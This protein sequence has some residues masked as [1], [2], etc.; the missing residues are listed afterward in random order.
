M[1]YKHPRVIPSAP[2]GEMRS[3]TRRQSR[4]AERSTASLGLH[5]SIIRSATSKLTAVAAVLG[6]SA[7]IVS[8]S[9]PAAAVYKVPP[10]TSASQDSQTSSQSFRA[11]AAVAISTS[12]PLG[13]DG[14]SVTLPPPTAKPVR[15][16]RSVGAFL[17]TNN[18]AG[19]IQWPF[20]SYV[21]IAS[22]FGPRIAP[23]GA[24]SSFHDGV[25]FLPG[26]GAAIGAIAPGIVSAVVADRG[27]YGTHVVVDHVVNG[28]NVQSTYAH[29]IAG[30]PTVKVGQIVTVAQTLGLVGNTGASTGAHLHLGISIQG[31][32]VDPF[33]WLKANAN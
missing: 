15:S 33:A 28:Q 3:L 26:G 23:C 2:T 17:Y 21:P 32:F 4:H 12:G 8:T 9:L 31:T 1:T 19:T 10:A 14:Y 11:V 29:M 30:S 18:P 27:G 25:D 22:G 20:P 24:C 5:R 6:V 16:F 7:L 13:R